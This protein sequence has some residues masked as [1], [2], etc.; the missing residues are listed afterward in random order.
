MV[1]IRKSGYDGPVP[2]WTHDEL[3]N[4]VGAKLRR[5]VLVRYEKKKDKVLYTQSDI[6][7]DFALTFL[8]YELV[9]GTI[10][11]D[12]DVRATKTYALRDHG[13]KFRIHPDNVCRVYLN[14]K[15]FV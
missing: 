12:F 14:K 15:R 9:R 13:T 6:F 2:Y 3:L 4:V 10:C 7:S 11:V 1:L 5:L 8:I